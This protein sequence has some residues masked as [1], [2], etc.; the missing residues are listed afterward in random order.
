MQEVNDDEAEKI[1]KFLHTKP[2]RHDNV[3]WKAANS[4]SH[5]AGIGFG[6]VTNAELRCSRAVLRLMADLSINF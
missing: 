1:G 4:V 5:V 3:L 2:R 6:S